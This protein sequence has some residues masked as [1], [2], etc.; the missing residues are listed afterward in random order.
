M[1]IGVPRE[2]MNRE[3]RVGTTPMAV[4]ALVA[5]GHEVLIESDAGVGSAISDGD[6]QAAGAT[7][8]GDA[9]DIWG[10]S[11]LIIKVKEPL[12][13]EYPLLR[14]GQILFAYLHLA[15]SR[16]CTDALL[17]AKVTGIAFET[18]ELPDGS[19]PLLAPMSEIA[20]RLA[21]QEGAHTL[22]HSQGGRG[23]LMGGV[24]GVPAAK[25][26]IIG[27]GS[28][29]MNAAT[30]AVGMGADVL[31]LDRD[32]NRL[33]AADGLLQGRANTQISTPLTIREASKHAD[34]VIGAVLVH[35]AKATK[36][37]TAADVEAM[38]RGS[39]LVD[40][41][42]DQGG[43]FE[44]SRPTTHQ[45]PTFEAHGCVF[46]CVR[47]MP[48]AVP[49]TSTWALANAT[50]PYLLELA[51]LGWREAV[52]ADPSLALGLNVHDGRVIHPAVAATFDLPQLSLA[53]A[54]G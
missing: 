28:A 49:R 17:A 22:L 7:I 53:A 30:V 45:E 21:A 41:S 12:P 23:V 50:T 35:G 19:L 25:V 11:D 32:V 14:E 51:N 29:G 43:C 42:I 36:L 13:E 1:K 34:I 9:Q 44:P 27:A 20:G 48:G 37:L 31:I 47:N 6:F 15:G 18:V 16:E 24:P 38:P 46:Y 52:R 5:G 40:I 33:R 10:S 3:Y 4:D 54:L 39:V 2:R 26:V 8:V